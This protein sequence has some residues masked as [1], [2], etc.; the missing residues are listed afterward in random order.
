MVSART[1]VSSEGSSEAGPASWL[2]HMVLGRIQFLSGCWTEEISSSLA[3]GSRLPSVPVFV[4]LSI[5]DHPHDHQ[6]PAEQVNEGANE[7]KPGGTRDFLEAAF[8]SQQ[9][10]HGR[11]RLG[12]A[13]SPRA[14]GEREERPEA[15]TPLCRVMWTE[16]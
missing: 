5:H 1:A 6:L 3:V 11:A 2:T 13:V 10:E 16:A 12:G 15:T 7:G 4:D 8:H 14:A 9:S